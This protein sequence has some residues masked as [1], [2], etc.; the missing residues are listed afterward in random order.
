MK[1]ANG[2]GSVFYRE[3]K[4]RWYGAAYLL[5]ADGTYARQEV[6]SKDRDET[7]RKLRDLQS[8]SDKGIPA[9]AT[10]WTVE[11]FLKYWLEHIVKPSK[12]PKTHQGYELVSR[13]HLIP[14]LGRKKLYKLSGADVR[15]FMKRIQNMCLCCLHGYDERRGD[16]ARCCAVGRCCKQRPSDRLVEQIHAVLRNALSAAVREEVLQRN[17]AKLV[18]V[19]GAQYDT[20]RGATED[21]ARL[22]LE[23]AK[24][25]RLY[26]LFALALFMGLRRGELLGLQW[27]DIDWAEK[28]VEIRRTLQRVDGVLRAVTPKTKKSRRTVPLIELCVD[29]LRSHKK[30]QAME[31][32]A[33]GEKWIDTGYVFTTEIGTPIE[34]DNLRRTWYP[35]RDA[36]ELGK[37]RFHDLRHSCVTL[38]LRLKVPPHIVQAI[39]GHADVQVTMA[40]YAHASLEDQRKALDQLAEHL[41]G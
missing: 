21:Q 3:S 12:K 9:E 39:V 30:Q 6:S 10:N 15:L 14:H 41:A 4:K 32:L 19:Q 37:M 18:Q 25:T 36:A 17:V 27:H 7:V 2:D 33:A 34:P 24:T 1:S 38:L 20:N 23:A 5:Q 29:A 31:R 22:L 40:V 35:L 28:T 13:V 16:K 26:A 11:A 8:K